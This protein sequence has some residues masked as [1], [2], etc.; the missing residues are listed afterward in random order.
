MINKKYILV[1]DLA[2]VVGS[3]MVIAVLVGYARPLVIAPL[4]ELSTTNTAVLF[5]FDKADLILIDDNLEFTSP[6][7]IY[8]EDNLVINLKPGIYY[9]KVVGALPGG[10]RKLTIES[11]IDLKLRKA[12]NG[13]ESYEIVNSGNTELNV[14]VYQ[15]EKLAGNVILGVDENKEVSGTK[16]LGRDNSGGENE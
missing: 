7:E 5:S 3:L 10:V 2:V 12:A 1:I 14:D 16:F 8:A 15:G 11:E 9:W 4:D 6:E 13:N